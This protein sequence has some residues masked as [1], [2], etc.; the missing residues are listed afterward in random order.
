MYGVEHTSVLIFAT[1][2]KIML[3]EGDLKINRK[4]LGR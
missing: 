4:T 3:I 2:G 1:R